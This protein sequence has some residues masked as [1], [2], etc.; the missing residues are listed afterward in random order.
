MTLNIKSL[1]LLG[2]GRSASVYALDDKK[3]LKLFYE[4]WS[5]EQVKEIFDRNRASENAMIPVVHIY[6]TVTVNGRSGLIMDRMDES[7]LDRRIERASSIDERLDLVDRFASMAGSIHETMIDGDDLPDQKEY[8]RSLIGLLPGAGHSKEKIDMIRSVIEDVP[9][10]NG[11]IHGDLHTGNVIPDKNGDMKLTDLGSFTGKGHF[12]W[13]LCC[14]YS[15]YVFFPSIMDDDTVYKYIG[16]SREAGKQVYDEFIRA[17]F[18]QEVPDIVKM[19][20]NVQAVKVYLADALYPGLFDA[21][22]LRLL[23]F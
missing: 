2:E 11:Y 5:R 21:D 16:M 20:R 14:M 13:D 9:Q 18:R 17:Y 12:L 4:G 7:S 3:A 6:E 23:P 1:R 19:I 22:S 8:A 10:E 15:H